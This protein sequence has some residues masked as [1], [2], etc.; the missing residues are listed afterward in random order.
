MQPNLFS[1]CGFCCLNIQPFLNSVWQSMLCYWTL[2]IMLGGLLGTSCSFNSYCNAFFFQASSKL[3]QQE[4]FFFFSFIESTAILLVLLQLL[5]INLYYEQSQKKQLLLHLCTVENAG[6]KNTTFSVMLW[7]YFC[8]QLDGCV[9]KGLLRIR[10]QLNLL[11]DS[12]HKN[13]QI[14][15]YT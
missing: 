4:L 3:E 11:R 6:D 12:S 1:R 7:L 8:R 14:I 5:R 2:L 15:I 9:F 10:A 13:S